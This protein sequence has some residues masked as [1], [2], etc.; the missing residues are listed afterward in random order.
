MFIIIDLYLNIT[1]SVGSYNVE[2]IYKK[3]HDVGYI[4]SLTVS[5]LSVSDISNTGSTKVTCCPI[6]FIKSTVDE[7]LVHVC[8]THV[9]SLKR[10]EQVPNPTCQLAALI[11]TKAQMSI[12]LLHSRK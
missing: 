2:W 10:H 8:D 5:L 11:V 6:Q 12:L 7:L 9:E 4:I 3:I 1:L